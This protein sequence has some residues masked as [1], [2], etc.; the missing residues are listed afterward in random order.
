MPDTPGDRRLA[1]R[2][3]VHER[4]RVGIVE[5][6]A[7]L[8]VEHLGEQRRARVAVRL[9]QNVNAA[10]VERL[11]RGDGCR[12]LGRMMGVIIHHGNALRLPHQVEAATD[13]RE[14]GEHASCLL[15]VK[16]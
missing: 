7:E 13:A 16:S 12:D 14:I 4:H 5:R 10:E 8:V 6:C 3:D 11:R 9:E 15:H 2:V 1:G